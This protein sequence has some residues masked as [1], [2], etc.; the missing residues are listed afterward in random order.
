LSLEK[1]FFSTEWPTS[2]LFPN[3]KQGN[4]IVPLICSVTS[5]VHIY[6]GRQ[7]RADQQVS[8]AW[9]LDPN[10]V[11]VRVWLNSTGN[12]L[13]YEAEIDPTILL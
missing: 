4:Q 7:Q 5:V 10:H 12:V 9:D 1:A 8:Q 11:T 3:K 13:L 6:T 2:F